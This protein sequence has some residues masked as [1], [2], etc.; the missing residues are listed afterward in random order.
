MSI[1]LQRLRVT[2]T[3]ATR[4]YADTDDAVDLRFFIDPHA[5]TTYPYKGWRAVELDSARNDRQQGQTDTYEIALTEGDIG[6]SVS[7]TTVP[8]G[9]AFENFAKV[10]SAVFFL[11]IRGDDWWVLS[12]YRLQGLFQELR[13][14]PG[15]IDSFQ[16]I[17]HGWLVMAERSSEI[18]MSTDASEGAAWHH[19]IIDGPLP[20]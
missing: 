4:R 12:S 18:S 19:I 6:M 7:G 5:F 2:H 9:I 1:H 8:R 3:T 11:K 14:V 17:D 10:R 15:T 13:Y 16:V 20:A